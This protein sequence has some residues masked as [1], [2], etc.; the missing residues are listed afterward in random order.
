MKTLTVF[1][2]TYNN[3]DKILALYESLNKQKNRDFRWIVIDDGSSD[4]TEEALKNTVDESKIDFLYVRQ[5]N[6]GKYRAYKK[7]VSLNESRYFCCV[8]ADMVLYDDFVDSILLEYKRESDKPELAGIGFP[9][10]CRMFDDM[11]NIIGG[12]LSDSVPEY[13]KLSM[14]SAKYGYHGEMLYAFTGEFLQ[15][16][17]IP[18]FAG[19]KFLTESAFL[20]PINDNRIVKWVNKAIAESVYQKNG[21]T[22]NRLKTELSSSAATLYSYKMG[23]IHHPMYMHRVAN[24]CLYVAWKK[25]TK[26]PDNDSHRIPISVRIPGILLEPIYCRNFKKSVMES[27]D[28]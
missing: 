26:A 13:G 20:F 18:E 23:A 10:V 9:I 6:G 25:L 19:E 17:E 11:D 14:L 16:I 5:P 24:C 3:R 4:G 22:N 12:V 28:T 27:K 7:A 21:I 8:D 15:K 2:P 1:T